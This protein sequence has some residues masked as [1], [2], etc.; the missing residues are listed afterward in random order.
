MAWIESHQGLRDH[1]K[2]SRLARSLGIHRMQ[3]IGHLHALWWWC[4]SYADDGDLS[5]F[6]DGEI[7]DAAG[8]DGDVSDFARALVSAGWLEVDRSVHDWH[9]YAGK[10]IERRKADA[11]R[12]KAGKPT[13]VPRSS[14]GRKAEGGRNRTV[15][16]EEPNG[17][18][19]QAIFGALENLFGPVSP[20]HRKRRG[21][22][23]KGLLALGAT[24]E[25]VKTYAALWPALWRGSDVTLTDTALEKFWGNLGLLVDADAKKVFKDCDQCRN[26][27]QVGVTNEG[28]TVAWD[29]EDAVTWKPCRCVKGKP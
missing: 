2:T 29:D 28:F 19:Q 22:V 18:S 14:N 25:S 5:F 21:Q 9:D 3:A 11:L 12:K 13:E 4:L 6:D 15:P 17:S 20:N 27:R 16:I 10:L 23:A 24:P 8:W 1:P 7:A 26:R